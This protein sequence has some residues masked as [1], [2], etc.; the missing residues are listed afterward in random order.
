[1]QASAGMGEKAPLSSGE[2]IP[3]RV[4]PLCA[5]E[6]RISQIRIQVEP[7]TSVLFALSRQSA[8]GVF[9]ALSQ[10]N[11]KEQKTS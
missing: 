4:A 9:Y 10:T 2:E 1:M 5:N 8:W 3:R 7:R 11:E 6:V